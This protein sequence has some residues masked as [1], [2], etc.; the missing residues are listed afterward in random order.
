MAKKSNV[1]LADISILAWIQEN[2]IKNEKGEPIDLVTH[3]FLHHIFTDQAQNL[4]VMKAAQVGMT[5]TEL[6][7]NYYDAKRFKMDI[8][9]CVD[10]ETEALT[11][12]GFRK[13]NEITLDDELLTLDLDGRST[14]QKVKE[15]FI[16]NVDTEMYRYQARNFNAFVTANHRWIVEDKRKRLKIVETKDFG[17]RGLYIP[18]IATDYRDP[19]MS[20]DSNYIELLSWVFSEGYYCKQKGKNDYSIII[21]QSKKNSIFC[22]QIRNCLRKNGLKWKEYFNETNQ[23]FNFRFAFEMGRKIKLNFPLKIPTYEFAKSLTREQAKLFIDTFVS[24]DGWIDKSG[25]KSITQQNRQCVDVLMMIAVIAGYIPSLI[26]PGKNN[27]YTIRMVQFGKVYIEELRP[28]ITQ[29]K[30]I[31]IWCPR[32]DVGTFYA[33]RNGRCYWTGNTLP[34]DG[35]VNVMVGGKMNRM[36]ANNPCMLADVKDKDSIEQKA[37]G[38][39]MIYFRGTFTKKA[40]TMVTADRLSHDEKDSSKLDIIADYQARLQHSK[41]KQTHTF[42]HPSLPEVGVHADWL[43]SDQKEWFVKCPHCSK[44]QYLSWNL[45]NPNKMSIDLKRRE[46]ICK[47]CKGVLRTKDRAM[48]QWVAKYPDRKW[49]GYHIPLLIAPWIT[50]GEII[51]KFNHKDTT[52]EFFYTKILGLPFA[53]G[54][55]KLL[56][57][58]FIKNLT[59]QGW[60][61]GENERVVIGIDTGLRLDYVIGNQKGLFYQ[62]DCKDYAELDLLMK[63]YP[64]AIAIIDAGGDL[65]GSR[66]FSEKWV[67]RVFLCSLAGDR[68]TKEL[69]KWGKG[70]ESGA[71]TADRNRMIQ[72]VVDEFRSSRIPLHG[73]EDDWYEYWLDWNNLSKS[74]V[75]DPETNQIKGYK[76]IRNGRD[77]R[78]LAT[79]FWR[80]GMMRFAGTGMIIG[81]SN[82]MRPNSYEI[83]NGKVSFD[84]SKFYGKDPDVEKSLDYLEEQ[85]DRIWQP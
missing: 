49:S 34:T 28:I 51:D 11:K 19:I 7:K 50:A 46:F 83:Q 62:G 32:T 10:V 24:A 23:C 27:A 82:E 81:S 18:K 64:R 78:A 67:G 73:T 69:V 55:S 54:T 14:W 2:N 57:Q 70:D 8:I 3:R 44:W 22:E 77:H 33:R 53:D 1:K 84:P 71:V 72:L 40:A 42:S 41:F 76:W 61:A 52:P 56:R 47:K 48:G 36:I 66:A 31:T 74:K 65:I 12:R 13:Y 80:V 38:K 35:D 16:N 45:E 21:S 15:V 37:I 79:C 60:S 25:T 39:S 17:K 85:G 20:Y 43:Q 68:K 5:T 75:L 58:D 4:T 59:G 30:D 63:R 26:N 6:I 29:E 9:Y